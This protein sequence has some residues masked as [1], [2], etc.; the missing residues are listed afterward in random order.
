MLLAFFPVGT[1]YQSHFAQPDLHGFAKLKM[2]SSKNDLRL[3]DAKAY[4]K[5]LGT[6]KTSDELM[7][8]TVRFGCDIG[9]FQP[10]NTNQ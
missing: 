5:S 9:M 7:L 10:A 4:Q 2:M 8:G 3:Q 6:A 1:L